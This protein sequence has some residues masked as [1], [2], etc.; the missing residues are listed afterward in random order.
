[1]AKQSKAKQQDWDMSF[2]KHSLLAKKNDRPPLRM[3]LIALH[4]AAILLRL[5][6]VR[7][8]LPLKEAGRRALA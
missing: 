7:F 2:A 3:R 8:Y 6:I 1:M 4:L 5:A